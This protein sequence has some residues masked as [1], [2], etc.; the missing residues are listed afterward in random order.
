MKR[1]AHIVGTLLLTILLGPLDA[2]AQ[3]D[4]NLATAQGNDQLWRGSVANARAGAWLDQGNLNASD[5]RK[6][7][8][9]GS[10][11]NG[12]TVAGRVH[13][14]FGG[15]VRSGEQSLS[16]SDVTIVGLTGDRF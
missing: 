14:I 11:G 9:V 2:W 15:P 6:D 12:T 1:L 13:I 3:N 8:I 16:T 5:A 10:P 4:L 7:L